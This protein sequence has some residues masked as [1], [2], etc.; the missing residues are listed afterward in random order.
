MSPS[1]GRPCASVAVT[2]TAWKGSFCAGYVH[3]TL[4]ATLAT[5][6]GTPTPRE[7]DQIMSAR[8]LAVRT[9]RSF[10]ISWTRGV[11]VVMSALNFVESSGK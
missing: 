2:N 10:V 9:M 7:M 8:S 1:I 11:S 4:V 5:G 6:G 3:F